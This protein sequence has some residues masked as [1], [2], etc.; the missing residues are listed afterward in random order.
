MK[1]TPVGKKDLTKEIS[2]LIGNQESLLGK[3]PEVVLLING[4]KSIEYTNPSADIFFKH[5]ITSDKTAKNST[6]ALTRLHNT[7]LR[8]VHKSLKDP[9][10]TGLEQAV[11]NKTHIEYT[12][13]PFIGYRGDQLYWLIIYDV[14]ERKN[15]EEELSHF[16]SNI[17]SILSSKIEDLNESERIRRQ[18]SKQINTL[19][20]HLKARSSDA[21]MIGSSQVMQSL[22]E[23]TIQVAESNATILITG[24]SGTGKEL[25]AN[26]IHETSNR[27]NKPFLKINCNAI[28]E[29]LLES[30]LFGHEKGSFTGATTQQKGKFEVVDGGTILLDEIGDISS[31]MQAALLRILQNGEIIRVGGNKPIKVDVR[32]IAAT[33]IDLAQAVKDGNFRLDLYYRLNIINISIPPLR[34]RKEDIIELVAHFIKRYRKAFKKNVDFVPKSIINRLLD[35][36]WPGNVRE[37]ENIIQ[38]AVLMA[39]T[40]IITDNDL[41]FDSPQEDDKSMEFSSLLE[42]MEDLTLKEIVAQVEK[43]VIAATLKKSDGNVAIAAK[44]LKIGKTAFYDKMKRYS[45]SPK[46]LR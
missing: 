24:E 41:I 44:A 46:P 12:I 13:A 15:K 21:D 22:R 16:H 39:K 27:R 26:L 19:K 37:L 32:I 35:H 6:E 42:N 11:V 8:T 38:R 34:E 3:M 5:L 29:S 31:R 18:L 7:L 2:R 33:N 25:V 1:P 17:E 14:T 20:H 30:D 4:D 40:N 43:H 23:M 36:D 28:N 45:I 10:P 9:N